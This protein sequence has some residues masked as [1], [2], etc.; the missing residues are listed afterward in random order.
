M[1][2]EMDCL[3]TIVFLYVFD[4]FVKNIVDRNNA[5]GKIGAFLGH[6]GALVGAK[7]APISSMS[8]ESGHAGPV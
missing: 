5:F 4:N 8:A 6:P 1:G 7:E 3:K 2:T